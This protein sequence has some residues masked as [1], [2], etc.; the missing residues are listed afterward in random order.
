MNLLNL[1]PY[2]IINNKDYFIDTKIVIKAS[3]FEGIPYQKNTF[4]FTFFNCRFKNLEIE[5]NETI[6][7]ININIQFISCF[8]GYINVESFTTTNF[9]I[10][11]GSSILEGRIFNS[12]LKSV[13]LNNC[14]LNNALFLLNLNNVI[15]LYDEDNIFSIRWKRL[16]KSIKI[17]FKTFL[18]NEHT[19]YIYDTN[20]VIFNFKENN[21][22]K[23]GIYKRSYSSE[24]ENKI[25][26]FFTDKEKEEFKLN[27]NLQY[28]ANIPHKIT[29]VVNAK[30]SSLSIKGYSTGELF[31]ENTKI[32]N[33]Y[34]HNFTTQL[35][36]NFYNIKPFRSEL[37]DK[38]FEIYNSNLDKV[39]FDNVSFNDYSIISFY[40]NKFGRTSITSCE[41]PDNY[42]GFDKFKT[43]ENIIN[44]PKKFDNNYYKIRYETFLQ[45]KKLLEASG[46]FYE[47]Q[48]FH[49]VSNEA[50]SK[51]KNLPFWDKLILKIN[52]L[53][54]N[55]G[56]SITKPFFAIIILSAFFYIL[57]LWSLGRIFNCNEIDYNLIGYYFSFL[58]ITHRSD[59]LVGKSELNGWS[60]TID[61]LNKILVGFLTYQFVAAF[62]KYG[63]K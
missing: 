25:G 44:I 1:T 56:L 38:K 19:Y 53:S 4:T 46:N 37:V 58:D 57:Y 52:S 26:Y 14:L 16:F 12:N 29:K 34:I 15:V 10:F 45:I 59:F 35:G 17:D 18:E 20:Y 43:V 63:K 5:N 39:W 30:L 50:L 3:D 47:S 41:F 8:I 11:F 27:L 31:I 40:R 2:S 7:F 62:R 33:L 13:T 28:S 21:S 60:V 61:Y 24:V 48:K 32:D 42:K 6:D 51:I 9:S 36:A 49:A 23:K 22:I 54:N 55:H